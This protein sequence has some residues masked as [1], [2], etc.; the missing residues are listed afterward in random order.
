MNPTSTITR[1]DAHADQWHTL[2]QLADELTVRLAIDAA[3]RRIA[4]AYHR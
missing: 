1:P 2:G 3:S 4:A